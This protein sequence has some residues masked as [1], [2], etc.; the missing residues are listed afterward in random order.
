MRTL[1]SILLLVFIVCQAQ[2]Q[3]KS[4]NHFPAI[5]SAD[6]SMP[7][8]AGDTGAA[9]LVIADVGSTDFIG[10]NNGFFTLV[11][12]R[13]KRILL[14]NRNA[15]D[16]ATVQ[17]PIYLGGNSSEEERFEDLTATTY[18]LE[19]GQVVPTV[20]DKSGVLTEKVNRER[21]IKKFT[22]PKL[23]EGSIIEYEYTVKSPFL[24][25]LR[26]WSFQSEYPGLW[27][28]YQVTI[29]P[30]FNY[31]INKK[32]F[33]PYVIDSSAK[34]FK[35]YSI[36]E[37]N[38]S[39]SNNYYSV[40]GDALVHEWAIRDV[41]AFKQE[42]FIS[43]SSNYIS[44]VE[45]QLQSIRYSAENTRQYTKDW[46]STANDMMKDPD[47]GAGLED[48]AWLKELVKFSTADSTDALQVKKLYE[49]V[50]DNF[51]CTDHEALW[52]SQPMKKTLQTHTGNVADIN[53]L[54]T[55]LLRSHGF[56]S[57]P[58]I[59]S[60]RGHGFPN[61]T[62]AILSDYNYVIC[63]VKYGEKQM[64]LDASVTR[65]GFGK[66]TADN[67]NFSGRIINPQ[68]PV[69]VNLSPDS[70]TER[71]TT[72]AV[73]INN[74]KNEIEGLLKTV[75]GDAESLSVRDK[76]AAETKE[77]LMKEIRK[78]ISGEL[79]V[80]NLLVDSLKFLDDPV[81]IS[82]EVVKQPEEDII[83]ITPM[84]GEAW[85]KNPF[86]AATRAYP[87]EMPYCINEV[88]IF[89]MEIPKG[90]VVD[91][92]PKSTRV[93]LNDD[94]GMFEYIVRKTETEVSVNC[95]LV[96][97]KANF[98]PDDY[99]VLRNFFSM[100]VKKEAEQIVFKKTN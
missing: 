45:F 94:E 73:F 88:Y 76:L 12:K 48:N 38:G 10:N 57:F 84:L 97:Y 31:L 67:Y 71:K 34:Q 92:I 46:F 98:E 13:K 19:N 69:L 90:Y 82:Y 28:S 29:P 36:I 80:R 79:K 65:L 16:I 87:V 83:Y 20:M 27:S 1:V 75:Y 22:F 18:N 49:Y 2:S 14:R 78:D 15:F 24:Y 54:L 85:K 60:T 74:E 61:N 42:G 91:E 81:A 63:L 44:R 93:K 40:S 55:G 68:M 26:A 86:T 59:L 99:E 30:M 77:D 53:I 41:P 8:P 72:I 4:V 66:L 33:L 7:M 50:R 51:K 21:I 25:R 43:A 5:S 58:V 89:N 56:E 35:R 32:G 62:V 11:F 95:R 6:F 9:A 70:V 64:L 100:V 17:V 23:K 39:S 52:I 96:L 47:F 37:Q 3:N